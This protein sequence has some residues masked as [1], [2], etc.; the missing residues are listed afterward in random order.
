[1]LLYWNMLC[2][3]GSADK[4]VE[5]AAFSEG[6]RLRKYFARC[7]NRLLIQLIHMNTPAHVPD[8]FDCLWFGLLYCIGMVRK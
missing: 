6:P 5:S 8:I 7:D 3:I 4:G 1:M 2:M